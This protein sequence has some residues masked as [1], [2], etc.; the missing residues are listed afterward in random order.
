MDL[1]PGLAHARCP[2]LVM[3]GD[4]DPV[5]PLADAQDIADALPAPWV[6]FVPFH[7]CGHGVWRDDPDAALAVL[8]R[9]IT[10]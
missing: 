10:A 1:L 6:Q 9:F 3:A 5:C 4:L 2:V 8:R 7:D